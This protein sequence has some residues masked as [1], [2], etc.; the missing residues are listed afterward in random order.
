MSDELRHF[1]SNVRDGD[2]ICIVQDGI[3]LETV[4]LRDGSNDVRVMGFGDDELLIGWT[5]S[6][7]LTA[8]FTRLQNRTAGVH[9][10]TYPEGTWVWDAPKKASK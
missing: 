8:P 7:D 3:S 4:A 1:L 5:D 10:D 9:Q 6:G 2:R